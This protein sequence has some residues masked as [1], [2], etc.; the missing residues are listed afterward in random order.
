HGDAQPGS[1]DDGMGDRVRDVM[2]FEVQENFATRA[3]NF[4]HDLRA[5]GREKLTSDLEHADRIV[6]LFD[7]LQRLLARTYIQDD[8]DLVMHSINDPSFVPRGREQTLVLFSSET[9]QD[10]RAHAGALLDHESSRCR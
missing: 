3:D 6:K 8:D 9:S 2:V 10:H 5:T 4:A 1:L 7:E